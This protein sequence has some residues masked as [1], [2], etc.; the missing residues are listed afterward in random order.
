MTP[1]KLC[2]GCP[3]SLALPRAGADCELARRMARTICFLSLALP[4]AGADCEE[5]ASSRV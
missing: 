2:A 3:V 4:R 1:L 5:R